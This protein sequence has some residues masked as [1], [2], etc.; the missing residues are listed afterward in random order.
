MKV[1][2]ERLALPAFLLDCVPMLPPGLDASRGLEG[3]EPDWQGASCFTLQQKE[4]RHI[5]ARQMD[6]LRIRPT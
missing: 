2:A 6:M 1:K 3:S 4:Q 5:R